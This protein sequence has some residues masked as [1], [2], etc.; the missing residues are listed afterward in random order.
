MVAVPFSVKACVV[1]GTRKAVS[2][3]GLQLRK[4]T[5]CL[6]IPALVGRMEMAVWGVWTSNRWAQRGLPFSSISSCTYRVA[7]RLGCFLG[8]RRICSATNRATNPQDQRDGAVAKRGGWLRFQSNDSQ[9]HSNSLW[10][11]LR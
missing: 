7:P 10:W 1:G 11:L 6:Y 3:T 2:H 5:S 9:I 4:D 8:V